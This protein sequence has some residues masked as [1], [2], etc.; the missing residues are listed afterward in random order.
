MKGVFPIYI[1]L[2]NNFI[3]SSKN[4][5]AIPN[6]EPP[7]STDLQ[8]IIEI[9]RQDRKIINIS[10]KEKEKSLII[11]D[12]HIYI[13]PISSITLYKRGLNYYKEMV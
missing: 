6:I 8:D 11:T 10:N 5:I 9:A 13:S 2:G 7:I 4:I 3:T 12:E 1:H